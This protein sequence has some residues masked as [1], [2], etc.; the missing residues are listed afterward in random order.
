MVP[1]GMGEMS[2]AGPQQEPVFRAASTPFLRAAQACL[3]ESAAEGAL[4]GVSGPGGLRS[5]WF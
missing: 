4:A 1:S 2:L 5:A 3:T